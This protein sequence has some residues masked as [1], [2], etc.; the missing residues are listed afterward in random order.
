[1]TADFDLAIRLIIHTQVPLDMVTELMGIIPDKSRAVSQTG[2]DSATD[3]LWVI[4]KAFKNQ[5][6]VG[7]GLQ[8]FL[9]TVPDLTKRLKKVQPYGECALRISLITEWG[10]FGFG[11]SQED[12]R[13][14][15]ELGIPFEVSVFSYGFCPDE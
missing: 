1:M 6:D 7:P 15:Y 5:T 8:T 11:L 14:L 3:N 13:I 4:K 12:L 10:M 9:S 2:D